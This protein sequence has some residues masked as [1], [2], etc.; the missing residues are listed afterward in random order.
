MLPQSKRT[1]YPLLF[2]LVAVSWGILYGQT[3]PFGAG[4]SGTVPIRIS[5][6]INISDPSTYDSSLATSELQLLQAEIAK[7]EERVQETSLLRRLIPRVNFSASYGMHDILFIDPTSYTTYLLPRDAYRLTIT[8]SL[9]E[10]LMSPTHA[11]AILDLQRLK[12]E[13]SV[14]TIQHTQARKSV[15]QQLAALLEDLSSI[16]HEETIVRQLLHFNEL[17]FQQ[18]KIEFDALART[19]LELLALQRSIQRLRHQQAELQLKLS[20]A[21]EH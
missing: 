8:L 11:Q 16:E 18:G 20:G 10:I 4:D 6:N 5:D 12:V 19:K 14:R 7:A 13:L 21:G 3:V 1:L 9:N 15:Q 2:V 17:R